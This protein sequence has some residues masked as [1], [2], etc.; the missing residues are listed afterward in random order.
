M[1]EEAAVGAEEGVGEAIRTEVDNGEAGETEVEVEE[2]GDQTL[3]AGVAEKDA[4]LSAKSKLTD[5]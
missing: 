3:E 4:D 5:N 2:E 1:R